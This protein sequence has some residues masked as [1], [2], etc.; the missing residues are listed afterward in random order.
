MASRFVLQGLT[1]NNHIDAVGHVFGVQ[2]LKVGLVSVAFVRARG[3]DHLADHLR[4]HARKTRIFAGIRNGITSA[5]GVASLLGLGLEVNVVDTGSAALL[6]HP[7]I[8]FARGQ[9]EARALIGSAN[10]T[11]P[12]LNNQIEA[13]V[14]LELNLASPNDRD[15]A[16][17]I[18]RQLSELSAQHPKNVSLV[19]RSTSLVELLN[20][21]RYADERLRSR[22]TGLSAGRDGE[23]P[24]TPLIRTL[25]RRLP[26]PV[27]VIELGEAMPRRRARGAGVAPI[28]Q[29]SPDSLDYREVWI[30]TLSRRDL[31]VPTGVNTNQ[32]GDFNLDKGGMEQGFPF[33]EVFRSDIFR[34]LDWSEPDRRRLERA[35]AGVRL[36]VQGLDCGEFSLEVTHDTKT[37]TRSYEQNN[38][39]TKLKW[40]DAKPYINKPELVGRTLTLSKSLADPRRFLIEID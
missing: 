37:D 18:E 20:D 1:A 3:V 6:F 39:M 40:G 7:K 27:P 8:Y 10:L 35:R 23:T 38:A 31:N 36:I 25:T 30:A 14:L 34:A 12:G 17:E 16:H 24:L 9:H 5:Q 19:A 26:R 13:S 28:P 22:S 29:F 4:P 33:Q 15:L 11:E 2:N 21:P 32:T